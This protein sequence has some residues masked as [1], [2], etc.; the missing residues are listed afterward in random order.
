MTSLM[1]WIALLVPQGEQA[2]PGTADLRPLASYDVPVLP[3]TAC[4]GQE[5]LPLARTYVQAFPGSRLAAVKIEF[6]DAKCYRAT[7]QP[8]IEATGPVEEVDTWELSGNRVFFHGKLKAMSGAT[9]FRFTELD[10]HPAL[11][12][13]YSSPFLAVDP[14]LSMLDPVW[15]AELPRWAAPPHFMPESARRWQHRAADQLA[16]QYQSVSRFGFQHVL[17]LSREGRFL[18]FLSTPFARVRFA[19]DGVWSWKGDS[20]KLRPNSPPGISRHAEVVY[21][22]GD[23]FLLLDGRHSLF[24]DEDVALFHW[25]PVPLRYFFHRIERD[26]SRHLYPRRTLDDRLFEEDWEFQAPDQGNFWMPESFDTGSVVTM[27]RCEI[28][29]S[30][31]GTFTAEVSDWES[32]VCILGS[33]R[34]SGSWWVEGGRI[35]FGS[36]TRFGNWNGPM[37]YR[38]YFIDGR[39]ILKSD[40]S[41]ALYGDASRRFLVRP[42]EH[43]RDGELP[44]VSREDSHSW[45]DLLGGTYVRKT[46]SHHYASRLELWQDGRYLIIESFGFGRG[47]KVTEG[48]WRWQGQGLHL[49]SADGPS[50]GQEA[51]LLPER[52]GHFLS[53]NGSLWR[54]SSTGL[55]FQQKRIRAV[56]RQ[57]IA[58]RKISRRGTEWRP[59]YGDLLE[60]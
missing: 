13:L 38:L 33:K 26:A 24:D 10:G 51:T 14:E 53:M 47:D 27:E 23:R 25:Y 48:T 31:D 43:V 8:G 41:P 34:V 44:P 21:R 37:G 28:A 45:K 5:T 7:F 29:F 46:R 1:L 56:T 19:Q 18:A 39:W 60:R 6:L 50:P 42:A 4:D 57:R 17:H 55:L 59:A 30:Q 11:V 20:L 3:P 32:A 54:K 40:T 58:F 16:R 35:Y 52:G 36:D 49:V 9:G 22:Q 2:P 12:S 15:T